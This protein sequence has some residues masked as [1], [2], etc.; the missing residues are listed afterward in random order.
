M[1]IDITT[2]CEKRVK[3]TISWVVN[4]ANETQL[5]LDVDQLSFLP[6]SDQR[7]LVKDI[8]S[9]AGVLIS[10][11]DIAHLFSDLLDLKQFKNV[12]KSNHQV[13]PDLSPELLTRRVSDFNQKRK[14]V[15]VNEPKELIGPFSEPDE[16]LIR[17]FI[18]FC[19][20][21]GFWLLSPDDV[22]L[23]RTQREVATDDDDDG[24]SYIESLLS[25]SVVATHP[26]YRGTIEVL[27]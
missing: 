14:F 27:V 26:D 20:V 24:M 11:V 21:T 6:S 15:M 17:D 18:L 1:N 5:Q 3:S 7:V 25:I 4:K 10:K 22:I 8:S 9:S 13:I 16:T 2:V 19:K 12:D 23:G